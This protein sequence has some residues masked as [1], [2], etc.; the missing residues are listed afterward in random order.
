MSTFDLQRIAAK[1]TPA[2]LGPYLGAASGDLEAAIRLY[3]WNIAVG[4]ALH[5]DLARFEIVIRNALDEQLVRYGSQQG[6]QQ[7]WYLQPG[8]FPG[9]RTKRARADISK[10]RERATRNWQQPEVHGK[11][12]AELS[13]G[14]WRFLCHN[15]Y[16]TSMWVPALSAAFPLH[17]SPSDP[18]RVRKDV[19]SLVQGL[20]F[21]RNRIAHHEPI[22]RR[23]LTAD[24]ESLLRVTGWICGHCHEWLSGSS[25]TPLVI[26]SRHTA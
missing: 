12:V 18:F 21:L 11:V 16:L 10:A 1:I 20:N 25:R 4:A 9:K 8:L 17:P 5:E 26:A 3:D 2:R 23:N 14:F 15:T 24:H 7:P 19:A 22:H 13:F 6:W